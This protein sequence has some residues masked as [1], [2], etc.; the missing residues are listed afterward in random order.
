MNNDEISK[1]HEISLRKKMPFVTQCKQQ[2]TLKI[3]LIEITG[4]S[5]YIR[6]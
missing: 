6:F 3:G 1:R 2:K 4:W 5:K